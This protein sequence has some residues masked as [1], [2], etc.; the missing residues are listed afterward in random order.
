MHFV[1]SSCHTVQGQKHI[2]GEKKKEETREKHDMPLKHRYKIKSLLGATQGAG[3]NQTKIAQCG[4]N[5]RAGMKEQ[6]HIHS[7]KY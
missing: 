2:I 7:S 3:G 5:D 4:S 1:Q 6:M